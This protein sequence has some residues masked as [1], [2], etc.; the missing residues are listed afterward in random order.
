[1]AAV[2]LKL[3]FSEKK[4]GMDDGMIGVKQIMLVATP[5]F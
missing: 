1:M 4:Y 5:S 2:F 3:S